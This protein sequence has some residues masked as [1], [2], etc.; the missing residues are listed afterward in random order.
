[1]KWISYVYYVMRPIDMNNELNPILLDS[2]F[3]SWICESLMYQPAVGGYQ[4]NFIEGYGWQRE[5][6]KSN[7]IKDSGKS[8]SERIYQALKE[9]E[10]VK[11]IKL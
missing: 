2:D 1:V 10:R 11:G 5:V 4:F 6:A 3:D 9:I 8:G 7:K